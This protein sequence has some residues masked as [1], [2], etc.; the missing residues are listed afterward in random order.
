MAHIT[1]YGITEDGTYANGG[2]GISP[3][4]FYEDG[5]AAYHYD[6]LQAIDWK[7]DGETIQELA[8]LLSTDDR[9]PTVGRDE[10][11]WYL[12]FDQ[13]TINAFFRRV[14]ERFISALKE[15]EKITADDMKNWY[16]LSLRHLD[17][18]FSD[19]KGDMIHDIENGWMTP[20]EFM[21]HVKPGVKY[22]ICGA[23]D[24]HC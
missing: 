19:E 4:D 22:Y 2:C 1:I 8:G 17:D 5:F 15:V 16:Q 3:D 24:A 7:D 14:W 20:Q 13:E 10:D 23:L 12:T 9:R 21:R 18:A 11:W 6:W